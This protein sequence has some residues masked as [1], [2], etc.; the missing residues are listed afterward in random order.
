MSWTMMSRSFLRLAMVRA[1][2]G[3]CNACDGA[4]LGGNKR[5]DGAGPP[6]S[7]K[8]FDWTLELWTG[9]SWPEWLTE[10]VWTG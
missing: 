10:T 5:Q 9:P 4:C 6:A 8:D 3:R 2:R 7:L 1:R